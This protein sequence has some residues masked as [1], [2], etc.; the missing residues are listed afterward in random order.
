[1]TTQEALLEAYRI[2]R[3][4]AEEK[5]NQPDEQSYNGLCDWVA[6]AMHALEQAVLGQ[7]VQS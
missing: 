7:E 5:D 2:G 1:M 4:F 6:T 3:D